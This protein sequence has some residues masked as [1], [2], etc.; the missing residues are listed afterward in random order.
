MTLCTKESLAGIQPVLDGQGNPVLDGQGN[1]VYHYGG[2]YTEGVTPVLDGL[3]YPVLDG[4]GNIVYRPWRSNEPCTLVP[5]GPCAPV[6][7][8]VDDIWPLQGLHVQGHDDGFTISWND[9]TPPA[10]SWIVQIAFRNYNVVGHYY[11]PQYNE[12]DELFIT[13]TGLPK[14]VV[15][16]GWIRPENG[17]EHAEWQYF[18]A[19]TDAGWNSNSDF[20]M[21]GPDQLQV[22]DQFIL[23]P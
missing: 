10:S 4:N 21:H 2:G 14:D 13:T 8:P 11:P 1:P 20:L 16:A 9:H 17:V 3:G 12:N 15:F 18:T 23:Y 19:L 5:T 7:E 6:V 22:G